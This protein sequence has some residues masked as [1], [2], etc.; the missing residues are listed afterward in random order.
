M[1]RII[2]AVGGTGGHLFPAQALAKDLHE[3]EIL[4][5]GGRLGGNP[6]FEKEAFPFKE[7]K[8]AS[9]F[10]AN[11]VKAVWQLLMGT[12]ASLRL[13]KS[14]SPD[15]VVGFGSFYSFPVLLAAVLKRIPYILVESNAHPGKVNRLFSKRAIFCALQHEEAARLLKGKTRLATIPSQTKKSPMTKEEAKKYYGLDQEL[16]TL[17][18]F[19]GSQGAKVLN[20]AAQLLSDGVQVLHFCGKGGKAEELSRAYTSKGINAV[21]KPFEE[22]MDIAFQASD[23]ALCRSGAGTLC[24]L[25][26]FTTPSILVPWPGSTENHQ[27]KNAKVLENRGGAI[28]LHQDEID[29]LPST[30]EMAKGKLIQMRESLQKE[31]NHQSQPLKTLIIEVCKNITT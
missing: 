6:F 20:R 3:H 5:A 11:P 12:F 15:F 24:E 16:F 4:F 2:L 17:L 29:A 28:V 8:G 21:V 1:V 18:I 9:P 23:L 7:I 14:F 13:L 19:G 31:K 26:E 25:I 30:F 22:R 27:Y 10:R